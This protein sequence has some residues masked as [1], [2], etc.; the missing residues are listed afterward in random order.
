MKQN[1]EKEEFQN[2]KNVI[3]RNEEATKQKSK[4]N[5]KS[6]ITESMNLILRKI[7]KHHKPQQ[8]KTP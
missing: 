6:V 2:I 3:S 5:L 7:N 1:M 8:F 4:E